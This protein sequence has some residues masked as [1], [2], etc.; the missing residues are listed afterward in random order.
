[1]STS[2]TTTYEFDQVTCALGNIIADGFGQ[3]EGISIEQDSP[4]FKKYVGSDGKTCRTKTLQKGAKV[5]VTLGQYSATNDLFA[6]LLLADNLA[7]NGAGITSLYIRDRSGRGLWTAVSA[8]LEGYP[9]TVDLKNDV[10]VK[11]WTIECSE[12]IRFDGGN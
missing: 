4:V 12:L 7:P 6:A 2:Q 5:K 9:E 11:V 10:T 8:W 3:D 1:M